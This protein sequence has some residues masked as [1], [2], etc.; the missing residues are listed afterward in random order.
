M[1]RA[2]GQQDYYSKIADLLGDSCDVR[3]AAYLYF[4]MHAHMLA[5]YT[6]FICVPVNPL[7]AHTHV[8]A[9][10]CVCVCVSVSV[11]VC[12]CVSAY[13]CLCVCIHVCIRACIV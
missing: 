6:G 13:V 5:L 12:L 10:V 7:Y 8:R 3:R 9:C 2:S 1:V 4:R 11:S